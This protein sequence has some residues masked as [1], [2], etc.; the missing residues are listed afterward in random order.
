MLF[1]TSIWSSLKTLV[2]IELVVMICFFAH[3]TDKLVWEML[4]WQMYFKSRMALFQMLYAGYMQWLC[5]YYEQVGAHTGVLCLLRLGSVCSELSEANCWKVNNSL[6]R[7]QDY[8][9]YILFLNTKRYKNEMLT[10]LTE[11]VWATEVNSTEFDL[12][13]T[14]K[15]CQEVFF[16]EFWLVSRRT[17]GLWFE[18]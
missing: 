9:S 14:R 10:S 16:C 6:Q 3:S 4:V 17:Y 12:Q 15:R 5:W 8:P 11:L 1:N 18:C 2:L 13:F 7:L